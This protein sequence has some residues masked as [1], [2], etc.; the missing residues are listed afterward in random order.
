MSLRDFLNWF[1]GFAEN[2]EA[3][4]T[5][6][7]WQR[8][9]ATIADLQS[10]PAEAEAVVANHATTEPVGGA[11]TTAWWKSQVLAALEEQGYD[12]E[13]AREVMAMIPIDLNADPQAVAARAAQ[14]M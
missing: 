5:A 9:V 4:P 12:P 13:S 3:A 1:E 2:I 8:I 14:G 11:G 10:A 6:K 7:Q